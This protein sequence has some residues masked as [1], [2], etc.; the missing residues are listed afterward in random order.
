LSALY[1]VV[2]GVQFWGTSFLI[3]S[4]G[5]PVGI[6]QA[7]FITCAATAPTLGVTFG[8]W[9]VDRHGGYKGVKQR[10]I[11]LRI[12]CIMG[13]YILLYSR[14]GPSNKLKFCTFF[15]FFRPFRRSVYDYVFIRQQFL[16]LC[17]SIVVCALL[18]GSHFASVFRDHRVYSSQQTQSYGVLYLAGRI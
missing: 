12:C 17:A 13:K 8:G 1:F 3:V 2:S 11:A 18:W 15:F 5:A 16:D 6:V 14:V 4:L 7:L 10:F 9:I